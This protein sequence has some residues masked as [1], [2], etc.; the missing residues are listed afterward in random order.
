MITQDLLID[1]SPYLALIFSSLLIFALIYSTYPKKIRNWLNDRQGV[2]TAIIGVFSV[3]AGVLAVIVSSQSLTVSNTALERSEEHFS[4]TIEQSKR[5]SAYNLELFTIQ[6]GVYE[7]ILKEL[8]SGNKLNSQ[9]LAHQ[10]ALK[11]I[12][13][14]QLK[15]DITSEEPQVFINNV[16]ATVTREPSGKNLTIKL[17]IPITVRKGR[18]AK[19]VTLKVFPVHQNNAETFDDKVITSGN[20]NTGETKTVFANFHYS[21]SNPLPFV[22]RVKLIITYKDFNGTETVKHSKKLLLVRDRDDFKYYPADTREEQEI[23]LAI[24]KRGT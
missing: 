9:T 10:A 23:E 22:Y 4:K 17:H 12:T 8:Q 18:P 7:A 1:G 2:F 24:K 5:D 11:T 15:L 16:K 19:E 6:L 13:D 21:A 20:I 14:A 3:T